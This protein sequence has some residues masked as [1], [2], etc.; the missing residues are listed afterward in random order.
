A[1]V[2]KHDSTTTIQDAQG[3]TIYPCGYRGGAKARIS[4]EA[5][6]DETEVSLSS[7]LGI[8]Q[9][10]KERDFQME[11]PTKCLTPATLLSDEALDHVKK[12][13]GPGYA[14]DANGIQ[15][16]IEPEKEGSAVAK[17]PGYFVQPHALPPGA[18]V[19][20]YFGD[21]SVVM[22]EDDVA[23]LCK[24]VEDDQVEIKKA[25]LNYFLQFFRAQDEENKGTIVGDAFKTVIGKMEE[26]M[27]MEAKEAPWMTPRAAQLIEDAGAEGTIDYYK[28]LYEELQS[29]RDDA[30]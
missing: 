2:I 12:M 14:L 6:F 7:Q 5:P 30:L 26:D 29:P 1:K 13:C 21:D 15:A 28:F 3:N 22:P 20:G 11:D 16:P 8:T 17:G 9:I 4:T 10:N 24:A 23:F 18:G 27:P 25:C 19:E